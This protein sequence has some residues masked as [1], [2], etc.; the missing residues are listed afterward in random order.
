MMGLN[1]KVLSL[2]DRR[3][4]DYNMEFEKTS[5]YNSEEYYSLT[6]KIDEL[7]NLRETFTDTDNMDYASYLKGR[8]NAL[9]NLNK[10]L[11]KL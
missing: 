2:I 4:R 5:L 8:Q 6:A 9:K 7:K 3:L 10:D 11:G 1:E